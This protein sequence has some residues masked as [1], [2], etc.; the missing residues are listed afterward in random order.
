M[1]P[2]LKVTLSIKAEPVKLG[3]WTLCQRGSCI[4]A[5]GALT[6]CLAL[7]DSVHGTML[8][9]VA[10]EIKFSEEISRCIKTGREE[11]EFHLQ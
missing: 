2:G 10:L 6:A 11:W 8:E 4:P 7:L 1:G 5:G 3:P 9:V